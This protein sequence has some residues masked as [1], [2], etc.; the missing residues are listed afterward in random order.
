M[1]RGMQLHYIYISVTAFTYTDLFLERISLERES[2]GSAMTN[3]KKL[4]DVTGPELPFFHKRR[5]MLKIDYSV[6]MP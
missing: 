3:H 2:R 6:K 1:S 4:I 5:G